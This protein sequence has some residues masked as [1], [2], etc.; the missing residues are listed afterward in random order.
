MDAAQ[1]RVRRAHAAIQ[2]IHQ[3]RAARLAQFAE[4][5]RRDAASG[6]EWYSAYIKARPPPAAGPSSA[7]HPPPAA[8]VLRQQQPFHCPRCDKI[9]RRRK[10]EEEEAKELKRQQ[11]LRSRQ[12]K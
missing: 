6:R 2:Q 4:L 5:D 1:A 12:K 7:P 9:W 3:E 8:S 10:K 11:G